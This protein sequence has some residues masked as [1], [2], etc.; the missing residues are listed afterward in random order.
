MFNLKCVCECI[1]EKECSACC[2]FFSEKTR[3]HC[4][5]RGKIGAL[6]FETQKITWG[7]D[8]YA[9][10]FPTCFYADFGEKIKKIEKKSKKI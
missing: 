4:T 3:A 1:R 2:V 10:I 7:P 8:F 6:A 9:E 5:L